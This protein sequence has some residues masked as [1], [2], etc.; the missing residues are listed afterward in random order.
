[1]G[2]SMDRLDRPAWQSPAPAAR[3]E[4]WAFAFTPLPSHIPGVTPAQRC[5]RLLKIALRSLDLRCVDLAIP[6]RPMPRSH[7]IIRLTAA[8]YRER[9]RP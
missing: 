1:M 7:S 6:G 8:D 3:R 2:R 4:V 9:R 5:R